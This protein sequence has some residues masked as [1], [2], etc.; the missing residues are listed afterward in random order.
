MTFVRK[1]ARGVAL[2]LVLWL[3]VLITGL[4]SAF[5]LTARVEAM[6]GQWLG[7]SVAARLA[8]ESGIELAAARLSEQEPARQWQADGRAYTFAFDGWRVRV[9]V[10]DESGKVDI[11]AATPDVMTGLLKA[12]GEDPASAERLAAA[13]NDWHDNDDLLSAGVGAEDPQ[14]AAENLPYGAKDRPFELVSELRLVLGMT[15]ALYQKLEPYVTVYSGRSQPDPSSAPALV[16]RA[17]GLDAT[18]VAEIEAQRSAATL[19][20]LAGTGS[21]T[22]SISSEAVR[23]DG[24]RAAQHAVV[25]LGAGGGNAGQLYTPLAWRVGD[26]D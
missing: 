25:R 11:N 6:Q 8:A 3:L 21:G 2:L 23:Q 12:L 14:Y 18:R 17:I 5:S 4:V 13:I 26:T 19:G 20:T 22:Y 7:R 24:A 9:R 15:P 10:Q 16:L 1:Q